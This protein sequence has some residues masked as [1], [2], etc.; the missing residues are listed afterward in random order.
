MKQKI[1]TQTEVYVSINCFY[2]SK[3]YFKISNSKVAWLL[4]EGLI[5]S[6]HLNLRTVLG[7]DI[8]F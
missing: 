5:V 2:E 6:L 7:R 4:A 3:N 1:I 8:E